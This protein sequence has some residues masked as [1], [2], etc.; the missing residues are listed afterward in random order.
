MRVLDNWVKDLKNVITGVWHC[1]FI[2][3]HLS[4][5]VNDSIMNSTATCTFL[6]YEH[7]SN[8]HMYAPKVQKVTIDGVQ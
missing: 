6:H 3:Y 8:L 7:D 5:L 1:M 2:H 4:C